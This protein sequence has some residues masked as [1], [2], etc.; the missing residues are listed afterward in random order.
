MARVFVAPV[1]I[2]GLVLASG[3]TTPRSTAHAPTLADNPDLPAATIAGFFSDAEWAEL[4]HRPYDGCVILR[5][6]IGDDHRVHNATP[7]EEY[8][9]TSRHHLAR[10]LATKVKIAPMTT[11]SH[12]RPMARI[13]V[14]FYERDRYSRRAIIFAEQPGQ[15]AATR[16][17]G[18]D[19]NQ[20]LV[21]SYY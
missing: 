16:R 13:Y 2:V 8:P 20:Y 14:L 6:P 21:M 4:A 17:A 10:R 11:G 1:A 9:D 12:I 15:V 7:V 19:Q 3:C 5:G 18:G